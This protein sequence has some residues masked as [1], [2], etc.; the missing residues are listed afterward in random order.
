MALAEVQPK[1]APISIPAGL[2]YEQF[3]EW[4]DED[5][6]AEW[7]DGEII[8]MS[9]ASKAHQEVM[10]TLAGIVGGFVR[11]CSLGEVYLPPFNQKPSSTLPGREP[12]LMFVRKENLSRVQNTF[13]NG[14]ADLVVEIISPE[15]RT[16][17]T[18]DKFREYQE[19]GVSE[20]WIVD[21]YERTIQFFQRNEAGRFEEKVAVDGV[22]HGKAIDGFWLKTSWLWQPPKMSAVFREWGLI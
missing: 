9:P 22:Y 1:A 4:A 10:T 17:D 16:R 2:S 14:P 15:S 8:V 20:Y 12:D 7:I 6:H 3:L 11:E 5:V 13:L 19:G 21:P 18:I